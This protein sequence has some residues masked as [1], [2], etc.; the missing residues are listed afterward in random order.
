MCVKNGLPYLRDALRS[1]VAQSYK[2]FELVVQDGG[3]TDGSIEILENTSDIPSVRIESSQDSGLGQAFS[4]ALARCSGDIVG[5]IDSD[6]MLAP[7][8]LESAVLFFRRNA[9]AGAMYGSLNLLDH[10][11]RVSRVFYPAPFDVFRLVRCE[12]V[13]PFA[14][15]FFSRPVCGAALGFD[16]GIRACMDFELW[17]RV[18]HLPIKMVPAPLASMRLSGRNLTCRPEKYDQFCQEKISALKAHLV[19]GEDQTLSV[20]LWRQCSAG[21]YCWAAESI[22]ELEGPS[23]RVLWYLDLASELD[24]GYERMMALRADLRARNAGKSSPEDHHGS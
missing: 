8:A 23:D 7:G 4:R 20:A 22:L 5:S 9:Y 1:V 14:A 10:T 2:H 3:S 12:L 24:P 19:C 15:S 17:L 6:N 18:A 11:G 16:E 21:V 13:P